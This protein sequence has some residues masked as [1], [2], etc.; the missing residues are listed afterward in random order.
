MNT[1]QRAAVGFN[2]LVRPLLKAPIIG[3][4]ISGAI[5]EITYT[6]RKSGRTFSIPISYKRRGDE[7]SVAVAF[8]DKKAWWRNFYPEGGPISIELDGVQRSGHAV[9]TRNGNQVLVKIRLTE[10]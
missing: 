5:T 6:G 4:Y 9:A 8:P 1:F 7:V 10:N 2:A 3:K